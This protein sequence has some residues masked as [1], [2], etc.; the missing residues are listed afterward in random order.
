MYAYVDAN[1]NQNYMFYIKHTLRMR[2]I[3]TYTRRVQ[4]E[5]IDSH[6]KVVVC[7]S[8]PCP[9]QSCISLQP[10]R[11]ESSRAPSNCQVM[12]FNAKMQPEA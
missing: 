11:V 1:C 3:I 12:Q 10:S 2:I 8:L 6:W 7:I 5:M 9:A 4:K